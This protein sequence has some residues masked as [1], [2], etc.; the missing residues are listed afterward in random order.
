MKKTQAIKRFLSFAYAMLAMAALLGADAATC[1]VRML[2]DEC[3]WGGAVILGERMPYDAESVV[4]GDML[5]TNYGN[6]AMPIFMSSKG[7]YI[8][9]DEPFAFCVSGG[10]IR[11]WS[12]V[13]D[14]ES[15]RPASDLRGVYRWCRD[16]WFPPSGKVPDLALV[17][18]PQYNTWIELQYNQNE[19]DILAYAKAVKDNGFPPGVMMIDDTWQLDYGTWEFDPRRF[20]DPKGMCEALHR[21]GFKV[22]LWMCPFVSADSP[23]YRALLKSGGLILNDPVPDI[24]DNPCFPPNEQDPATVRWWNGKS[25]NLDFTHPNA[26]KWFADTLHRLVN[27]FGVDGFKLDAG[28]V[29]YYDGEN[30]YRYAAGANFHDSSARP[31]DV[32]ERYSAIGLEFPLN[33]YRTV[34]GHAGQPLVLRLADKRHSWADL[35]RL[36]PDMTAMGLAGYPFVCPD[37]IGGG[38]VSSFV[39]GAPGFEQEMFVRSAQVHALCPM[40]QFSAA[41]W[42]V[43]DARQL[44]AVR[45]AVD[46]RMSFAPK[47]LDLARECAK[48]GEPMLRSMAYVFPG[49]GYEKVADQFMMGDFLMVAPQLQRGAH[50]RKVLIPPGRWRADDGTKIE[51]PCTITVRT[52]IDRI[53]HYIWEGMDVTHANEQGRTADAYWAKERV[54]RCPYAPI[55]RPPTMRDELL[56]DTDYY[57]DEFLSQMADDGVNGLWITI[58]LREVA[59]TPYYPRDPKAERRL[60]KLRKVVEKCARHGIKIWLFMIEPRLLVEGDPLLAAHPGAAGEER[61]W[62]G[63][64]S[65]GWVSCPCEP[66]VTNYLNL[67]VKDVFMRV[68][69]LGGLI[70]ITSGER[71][72]TCFSLSNPLSD[73]PLSCPRCSR[74][75]RRELHARIA[76]ALADGV[77]A[78]NPDAK[79]VSWLYHPQNESSRGEWVAE[80]ARSLPQNAVLLY[81]FESGSVREQCG[82][83]RHGGDYWLSVPGPAAPYRKVASAARDSHAALGAKIQVSCSH[84][85]ATLPYVPVPALLYRKYKA[86]RNEGVSFVMQC[87]YFGGSPGLMNRAA[88]MLSRSDFKESEDDFLLRLAERDWGEDAPKM[89]VLWKRFSEAYSHYPL[90][91][92]IQYYGPFH[93]SCSWELLPDV[94]MRSLSRTWKP[95]NLESGDMIGEALPD[96]TLDDAAEQAR[97]MCAS[98]EDGETAALL[99][100]FAAKYK[101]DDA[102]RREIGI[103]KAMRDIF[104]GGRDVFAFYLARRDGIKASRSDGDHARALAEAAK[105]RAIAERAKVLTREMIALCRDDDRLGYHPEA[106]RKQF[107]ADS[108]EKRLASLDVT[109]ARLGEIEA[110]LKAGRPWPESRRESEAPV[111]KAS[112]GEKGEIVVEGVA[113]GEGSIVEVRAYDLCATRSAV[114]VCRPV[115][116]DGRFRVELPAPTGDVA[117]DLAWICVRGGDEIHSISAKWSWPDVPDFGGSR[118]NLS[119]L[120]GD[121]FGRLMIPSSLCP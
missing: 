23:S 63:S 60:A 107:S 38:Q 59:D 47:F 48:T 5:K 16:R 94:M 32:A 46:L 90:S 88:G 34:W 33:E 82:K 102:R 12:R 21:D 62:G 7:R 77:R 113:S 83:A 72:T 58:E 44:E 75:T 28:D 19:K 121:N 68:P 4:E 64:S 29:N 24:P 86:M 8:R 53:P 98:L 40:M 25:A 45:R 95:D 35:A 80:C 108:L 57:P 91:K 65:K 36:I 74:H 56:E 9:C 2:P 96:F 97:I 27:D 114:V 71:Y 85:I 69:G 111:W 42:R 13:S 89:A 37:M 73:A 15:G 30:K 87:W 67:A 118:L 120:T 70:A 3:W 109:L 43:L 92:Q 17:S 26:C 10:V 66:A 6:P 55:K 117:S 84:E 78:G 103:M 119:R 41:P 22:M 54:A 110:E 50:E 76:T 99:D 104:I 115:S 112:R 101:A 79:F 1:E 105:M 51:G 31:Q 39:P 100:W 49:C 14:F 20:S 81:N 61:Y 106:E 18:A 116:P 52:P 11:A 93:A